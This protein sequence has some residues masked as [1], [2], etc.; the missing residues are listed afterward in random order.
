MP[1]SF[2]Q[3]SDKLKNNVISWPGEYKVRYSFSHNLIPCA[4][5]TH[6]AQAML[7]P[8]DNSKPREL[9]FLPYLKIN[10]C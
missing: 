8:D 9:C 6:T 7:F 4:P 3:Q 2:S 1:S 10:A 5:E